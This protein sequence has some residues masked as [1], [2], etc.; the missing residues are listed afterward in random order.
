MNKSLKRM[1]TMQRLQT[2][3]L[4][5]FYAQGYYDTSVDDI[6]KKLELSKKVF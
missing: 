3:G 6:L 4:E 5:L 2:T 1:A